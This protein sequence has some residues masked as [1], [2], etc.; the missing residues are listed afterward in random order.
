MRGSSSPRRRL[1]SPD[2]SRR[3]RA[4]DHP[5][6]PG[7]VAPAAVAR[8][9]PDESRAVIRRDGPGVREGGG[10]AVSCRAKSRQLRQVSPSGTQ[11]FVPDHAAVDG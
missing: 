9:E 8:G 11:Q 2:R 7:I 5:K 4:G 10:T 1:T 3:L 6:R